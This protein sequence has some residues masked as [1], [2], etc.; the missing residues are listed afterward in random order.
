MNS[1][2]C[3]S[4]WQLEL[5]VWFQSVLCLWL[6]SFPVNSDLNSLQDIQGLSWVTAALGLCVDGVYF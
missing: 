4:L 6:L 5:S 2:G 3:C 1:H